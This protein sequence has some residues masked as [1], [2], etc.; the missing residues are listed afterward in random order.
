MT[1][2]T[3]EGQLPQPLLL[4]LTRTLL[5][6][7]FPAVPPE[8]EKGLETFFST[9][10]SS[11]VHVT[12]GAPPPAAARTREWA[13]L[14]M[15]ITQPDY[16]GKAKVY[17]NN[18]ASGMDK[19]GAARNAFAEDGP[20]FDAEVDRYYAA[21]VFNTAVAPNRPL[22]P[23]RDFSTTALTTDE[24]ELMRADLLTPASQG[25]YESLLQA[26]KHVG[27]DN[28]GLAM[29]AMREKDLAKVRAYMSAARKAGTKNFVVLTAYA[30]MEND[31]VDGMDAVKEALTI[32]PKY[33]QAHWVLGEK[34]T[35]PARRAPEWK[36]AVN[37]APRNYEWWAQYA[38]LCIDL[39]QYAE[40]GRAWVGAAQA[41]PDTQ[42]REEYL[43]ARGRIDQQRLE[44]EDAARRKDLEA[45]AKEIEQLK[46][47]ARQELA[48]LEAKV[49]TRPLTK[50]E[51]AHT[52]D[53]FDNSAPATV[54]GTLIKVDC[55]GK[56]LRLNVRDEQGKIQILL[57][58][59]PKQF[60]IQN[61]ESSLSCGVQKPR[62]VTVALKAPKEAA[63]GAS[64]EA[65]GLEFH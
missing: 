28:E 16:A 48:D 17:L 31:P 6:E 39:K 38:Q 57:V 7:N 18:L 1:C 21:G 22:N 40:A 10:Q 33:A 36:L 12:W 65:T 52:V 27:E 13:L 23:E 5:Q 11:A 24:G 46:A 64:N 20:K 60:L 3:A 37:L 25:I 26:G 56:Q 59:D 55:A 62:S 61:G 30:E 43:S 49:N 58:T 53:W 35:E 50:E 14:H 63:K 15:I 32:D 42:R 45:K 2:A 44:D 47:R 51:A 19:S 29:L 4:D 41:A 34:I 9:V 8:I 54:T